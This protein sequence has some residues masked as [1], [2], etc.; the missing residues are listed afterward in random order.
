[1]TKA[2]PAWASE[3]STYVFQKLH[4]NT[5][6][7]S[8]HTTSTKPKTTLEDYY[9]DIPKTLI[10]RIYAKYYLDFVLLGFSS[11]MVSKIVNLGTNE[12]SNYQSIMVLKSI[13]ARNLSQY[14]KA[15]NKL[16]NRLVSIAQKV[17]PRY[18]VPYRA[19]LF[20]GISNAA[21]VINPRR[22]QS[23]NYR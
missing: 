23:F 7:P 16:L 5:S 4:F 19:Y 15:I 2:K 10:K 9:A 14:R 3:D 13:R 21:F 22:P 1:M 17:I 18:A 8:F 6:L 12:P 11:E 20:L